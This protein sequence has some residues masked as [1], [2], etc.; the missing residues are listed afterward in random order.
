[1]LIVN[2]FNLIDGIDSLAAT[3]GII[4]NG[5]FAL[6]FMHTKQYELC[7]I[8]LAIVGATTG[9][10]RYN[11][12]P[13]KIFMGDTGA[14]LIGLVSAVMAIKFIEMGNIGN[15]GA[16]SMFMAPALTITILIGPVFDTL[17]VFIIRIWNGKSPFEPDRNHIHHRMLKLGLTHLQTTLCLCAINLASIFMVLQLTNCSNLLLIS[18]ILLISLFFNWMITFCIRS[19]ERENVALRNFFV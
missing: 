19:K 16:S 3:T 14:L 8:C 6:L 10:L 13:A 4:V 2:S 12:T 1:M 17:R 11:I 9:F 18:L 7:A 5:T 15:V